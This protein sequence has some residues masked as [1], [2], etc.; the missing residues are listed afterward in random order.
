MDCQAS[1]SFII[2]RSLLKLMS[3]KFVM[4]SNHLI[5][6]RHLLL[7]P[8]VFPS[9]R[10]FSNESV[11]HQVARVFGEGNGNPLQCSCL[12]NPR[13]GGA[14]WAAVSG[15]AQSRTRLKWLSSSSQSIGAS[16]SVSSEYSGLILQLWL[17]LSCCLKDSQESSPTPQVKSINSS[18]LSLLYGPTLTSKHDYWKNHG[19]AYTDICWQSDVSVF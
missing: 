5:Q 13:D 11:L 10:V 2:S 16:A 4:P 17:V 3:I 12:E 1:L 14:W 6:C 19:F 9:I 8:S 18:A 7:L 15:V